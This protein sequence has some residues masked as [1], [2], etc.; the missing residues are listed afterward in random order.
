MFELQIE[1]GSST[2]SSGSI[3]SSSGYGSQNT[4]KFEGAQ[5][6]LILK[7]PSGQGRLSVTSTSV[8]VC[9][10]FFCAFFF[11]YIVLSLGLA[12]HADLHYQAP[13]TAITTSSKI[14][15][16]LQLFDNNINSRHHF[17]N[18]QTLNRRPAFVKR[19]DSFSPGSLIT[20]PIP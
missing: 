11:V 9:L 12:L 6:K 16:P 1:D 3:G 14:A 13:S 15:R 19:S 5:D 18:T 4:V 17:Y 20:I 2:S 10:L 8:V 7:P